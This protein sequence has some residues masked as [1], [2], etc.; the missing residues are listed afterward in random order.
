MAQNDTHVALIILTA[1]MWGGGGGIIGG[2]NFFG[3]KFVFLRL[4]RQRPF[5]DKT[6][7]P[8]QNPISPTP[9]PLLRRA[10]MSPPPPCRAIFRSPRFG[11]SLPWGP[12]G[13]DA[14][15]AALQ[16]G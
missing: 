5:L 14:R 12:T 4:R 10:S 15:V 8:T 9:P 1:Q 11:A 2:K 13:E 3:P 16:P 7:G 6:K